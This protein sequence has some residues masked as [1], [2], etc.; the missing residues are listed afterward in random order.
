MDQSERQAL[1]FLTSRGLGAA[2]YEPEGKSTPPDFAINEL[3]I[4]VRRLNQHDEN[5]K[6][7][8]VRTVPLRMKVQNLLSSFG[9]AQGA[10]WFVMFRYRRPIE[11]WAT[12]RNKI[13]EALSDFAR[14]PQE[15]PANIAISNSFSLTIAR[16]SQPFATRYVLGGYIDQDSGGFV[17]AELIRNLNIVIPEKTAKIKKASTRYSEWWLVLI[18]HI[19]LGRLDP[20]ELDVVRQHV[21]RDPAWKEIILVNPVSP[22][23]SIE[24]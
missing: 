9:P 8:E 20:H 15:G 10:S 16:A 5:G 18:D 6:G 13:A 3:A 21:V 12:L 14:F 7:L 23:V 4:E 19:S 1:A 24:L 22:E 2:K 11:K 17:A